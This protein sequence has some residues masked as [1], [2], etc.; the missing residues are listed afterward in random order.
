MTFRAFVISFSDWSRGYSITV[1]SLF[2]KFIAVFVPCVFVVEC[3]SATAY[4]LLANNLFFLNPIMLTLFRCRFRIRNR[5][6]R[7]RFPVIFHRY[8]TTQKNRL[9]DYKSGNPLV[10]GKCSKKVVKSYCFLLGSALDTVF[11]PLFE[12]CFRFIINFKINTANIAQICY[13]KK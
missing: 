11:K 13:N 7:N 4:E 6:L 5:F 1:K 12:K 8:L 9:P 10:M 3:K 2:H